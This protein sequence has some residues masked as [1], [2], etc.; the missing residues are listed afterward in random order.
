MPTPTTASSAST[1]APNAIKCLGHATRATGKIS[2]ALL[3][4]LPRPGSWLTA[5][6]WPRPHSRRLPLRLRLK[7]RGDSCRIHLCSTAAPTLL[8][9]RWP[10]TCTRRQTRRW[11]CWQIRPGSS[12]LYACVQDSVV[13]RDDNSDRSLPPSLPPPSLLPPSLSRAL[14]PQV[15]AKVLDA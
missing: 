15:A 9:T 6:F 5:P 4:S 14:L 11:V 1:S 13:S 8:R 10:Q 7:R 3:P 2:I 12:T